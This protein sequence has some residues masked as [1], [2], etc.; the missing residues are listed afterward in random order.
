M[1]CVHSRST[2]EIPK[3]LFPLNSSLYA[4]IHF[5]EY[6]VRALEKVFPCWN[7]HKEMDDSAS[8]LHVHK[9]YARLIVDLNVKCEMKLRGDSRVDLT[10]V[11]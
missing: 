7:I 10:A 6:A 2:Y 3:H 9:S 11:G 8:T 1:I 5:Q 4:V